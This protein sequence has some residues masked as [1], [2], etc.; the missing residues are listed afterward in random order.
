VGRE[1]GAGEGGEDGG[2][3]GSSVDEDQGLMVDGW[4]DLG[5]LGG[6]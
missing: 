4:W 2:G 5:W 3:P 6:D 1:K